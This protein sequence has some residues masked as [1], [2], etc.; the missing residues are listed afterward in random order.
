MFDFTSRYFPIETAQY[1][2]QDGRLITYVRRRFLPPSDR[3]PILANTTVTEGVRL[4]QIAGQAYGASEQFWQIGDASD[5]MNPFE[6][7]AEIGKPLRIPLPQPATATVPLAPF[8]TPNLP[9][10]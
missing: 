7:M 5:M 2:R 4:D 6:H 8:P 10:Q 3:L 1:Q 9:G